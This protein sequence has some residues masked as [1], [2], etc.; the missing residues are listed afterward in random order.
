M[1]LNITRDIAMPIVAIA[2]RDTF[3]KYA[4]CMLQ[5]LILCLIIPLLTSC[6]GQKTIVNSLEEKEANEILVFLS[7]KG[8]DANKAKA[9]TAGGGGSK[10]VLWDINVSETKATEAMFLLNQ[11]GLPR[12][13]AQNL[14]G[15]FSSSELVPSDLKEKIKYR[16]GLSEQIASTIRKI[17]GVLDAEVNISFPE[18]DPLN[19]GQTKGKITA[20]VYV[21][22]SGILDDPNSHLLTKIKRLVAAS[23]TGLDYDNVTV[24]SEKSRFGDIPGSVAF[25]GLE[26]EKQYV[27][28]W[29]VIVARES[30]TRFRMIFFSFTIALL[31]MILSLAWIFWKIAPI[32]AKHG[33]V[34]GL[35][36]LHSLPVGTVSLPEKKDENKAPPKVDVKATDKASIDKDMDE[37]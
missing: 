5:L 2:S 36:S 15:I 10:D 9:V 6:E 37:T 23:V 25:G 17:D 13:R 20:S 33:G 18:E 11:Q 3:T 24:I 7:T 21:K 30:V 28:I 1:T 8:I 32:L 31:I 14:L 19:P 22:H 4:R 35:F 29:S 26:E 27:S 34:K 12:R 16:A